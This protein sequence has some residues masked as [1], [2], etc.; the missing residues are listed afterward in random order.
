MKGKILLLLARIFDL[1]SAA[2]ARA[3]NTSFSFD[4]MQN[5]IG[6][7]LKRKSAASIAVPALP[8]AQR[9]CYT[10]SYYIALKRQKD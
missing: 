7:E 3:K 8:A 9:E 1:L 10:Y 5:W 6:T 4:D 2:Y